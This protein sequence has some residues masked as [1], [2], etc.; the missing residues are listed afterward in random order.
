MTTKN[1]DLPELPF[2]SKDAFEAWLDANHAC[3]D[4]IWLVFAK[5]GAGVPTV[6]YPEAVEVALC[7]GWIDGQSKSIDE[8]RYK[9]RYTPRRARSIWSKI[10]C[11]K[12]EA[13][14]AA[15]KMRPAGL[16][17]VERAKADG[18]WDA[19]YDPPSVAKSAVLPEL[20]AAL[21]K[22][23]KARAFYETLDARNRFALHHRI[24][25]AKKE[26]TRAKRVA[27]FVEMLAR[28]E[29]FH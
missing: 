25:T 3:C 5:K 7:F 12:A 1:D 13:L 6:T 20:E 10:N 18:R 29:K 16:R 9:Q 28:G 14:I 23:R 8:R 27:Q 26:E 2:D 11:G 22:N 24:Q 21:A 15:G 4:G 17:E 19:A